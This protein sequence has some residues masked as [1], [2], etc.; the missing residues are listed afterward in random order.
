[1]KLVYRVRH[2]R[3]FG[4]LS[5]ISTPDFGVTIHIIIKEVANAY[6]NF[7]IILILL[8]DQVIDHLKH[9][10]N[11]NLINIYRPLFE[12]DQLPDNVK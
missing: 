1:M 2:T 12:S 5:L 9:F 11:G 6:I 3:S 7:A 4:Y 10:P 8:I